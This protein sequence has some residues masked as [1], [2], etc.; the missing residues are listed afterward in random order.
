MSITRTL[1]VDLSAFQGELSPAIWDAL[2]QR[3][4]RFAFVRCQVG[5]SASRDGRFASDVEGARAAGVR[6]G[7]Y[8]VL[9][10]TADVQAQADAFTKSASLG[11]SELVGSNLGELPPAIDLEWPPP[12]HWTDHGL[13]A[14][15]IVEKTLRFAALLEARWGCVPVLYSYPFYL[16]SLGGLATDRAAHGALARFPLWIAGGRR[17]LNGDGSVPGDDENPPRVSPWGADWTFWQWDGDGGARL[18]NISGLGNGTDADFNLFNG[19]ELDLARFTRSVSRYPPPLEDGAT[20]DEA[21]RAVM[22]ANVLVE[23][24]IRAYRRERMRSSG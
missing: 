21:T 17:Y 24:G 4:V 23:D 9:Y 11:D 15:A 13:T 10:P 1:G 3:G 16:Q 2:Y 6:V 14:D 5:T 22:S 18:P 8:A 19:D 12:E 7:P 20:V